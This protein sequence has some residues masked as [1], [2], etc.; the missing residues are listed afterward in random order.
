ME[1]NLV[2]KRKEGDVLVE[3]LARMNKEARKLTRLKKA[4]NDKLYF[5]EWS[6]DY[7]EDI[8]SDSKE[9]RKNQRKQKKETQV[10]TFQQSS[11]CSSLY[12]PSS[13]ATSSNTT[14]VNGGFLTVLLII[15]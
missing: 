7:M 3:E 4:E 12:T 2:K 1:R 11:A 6:L 8:N 15:K 5:E 13:T 14:C 10:D 9:K